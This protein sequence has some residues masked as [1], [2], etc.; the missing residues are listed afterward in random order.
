MLR[1]MTRPEGDMPSQ[2]LPDVPTQRYVTIHVTNFREPNHA[3]TS[4]RLCQRVAGER[5]LLGTCAESCG[6][7]PNLN[8][9]DFIWAVSQSGVAMTIERKIVVGLGDI[10]SVSFQCD[11]C[12]YRVTMSPDEIREI[13]RGCPNGHRWI[14]GEPEASQFPPLL[15]FAENLGKLRTATS[16]KL[17]GF[18]I[19]LEFDEPAR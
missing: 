11:E 5:L 10:K 9:L 19:L 6:A 2:R 3:S 18:Q 4:P 17:L 12:K 13:P 8:V 7:M 15:K 1:A 16:Q 14:Q